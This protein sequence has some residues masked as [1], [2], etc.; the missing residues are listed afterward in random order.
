M[1]RSVTKMKS[2]AIVLLL[3]ANHVVA[4]DTVK[5][6]ELGATKIRD[7]DRME[8]VYV[9]AGIFEMGSSDEQLD[10]A[11]EECRRMERDEKDCQRHLYNKEQPSHKVILDAFWIDRTEVTNAQFYKF[12]NHSSL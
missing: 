9:P 10:K 7:I 1:K 2:I 8:M 3:F 12:L 4:Q 11:I 6:P 5:T